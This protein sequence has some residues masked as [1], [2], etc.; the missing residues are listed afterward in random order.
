[1]GYNTVRKDRNRQGGRVSIYIRE[2]WN[3]EVKEI[4][5]ELEILTIEVIGKFLKLSLITI[6]YTPLGSEASILDNFEN[7][8]QC[9]RKEDKDFIILGDFNCNLLETQKTPNTTKLVS[10]N[11]VCMMNI[12]TTS[13]LKKRLE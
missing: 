4:N 9:L 2:L 6:W 13:L 8:L 12:S 10:T 3:F 1:V 11:L 7:Y 5:S